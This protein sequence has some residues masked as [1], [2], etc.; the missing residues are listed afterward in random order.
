MSYN[1]FF[2]LIVLPT[3]KCNFRCKYCYEKFEKG[4]MSEKVLKSTLAFL[5]RISD[6]YSR[7]HISFFGGEPLIAY[8]IIL[9]ILNFMKLLSNE[10]GIEYRGSVSTN[11]YLLSMDKFRRLVELNLTTFQITLDG[12]PSFHDE[13][14]ITVGNTKTF[15]IILNNLKAISKTN[16]RFNIILRLHVH[17]NNSDSMYKL[18]DILSNEFLYDNRFYYLIRSIDNLG[19]KNN[20]RIYK[21]NID[22]V[23]KIILYAKSKLKSNQIVNDNYSINSEHDYD[24]IGFKNVSICYAAYPNSLVIRSDGSLSKCTVWLEEDVNNLGWLDENGIVHIDNE[25]LTFWTRGF[26]NG[27]IKDIICPANILQNS[28]R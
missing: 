11:G 6:I 5:N 23:N 7:I 9:N 18:I 22:D 1:D 14:R 17:K 16:Y 24:L 2:H 15:D 13:V 21:A 4:K 20:H 19:D 28:Y 12:D 26:I 8:D 27:H 3:E 10:K 25:K